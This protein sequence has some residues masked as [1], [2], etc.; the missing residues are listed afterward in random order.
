MSSSLPLEDSAP[1]LGP[2]GS[3]PAP[4]AGEGSHQQ[5]G[6]GT[7]DPCCAA[8]Q[9]HFLHIMHQHSSSLMEEYL[10]SASPAG[11]LG[12][13]QGSVRALLGGQADAAAHAEKEEVAQQLSLRVLTT[14]SSFQEVSLSDSPR[15][16]LQSSGSCCASVLCWQG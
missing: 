12:S 5:V 3:L 6:S 8:F 7:G 9:A 13:L 11:R 15:C 1:T 16:S 10:C 4:L 2:F 14:R